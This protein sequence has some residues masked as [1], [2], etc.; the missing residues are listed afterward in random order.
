M[1]GEEF[2]RPR[3]HEV[4]AEF[5]EVVLAEP[6]LIE[7]EDAHHMDDASSEL[8]RYLADHLEG[9]PWLFCVTRRAEGRGFTGSASPTTAVVEP[10]PLAPDDALALAE[11]AAEHDPLPP[12][13]LKTVAERSGGNPQ[14]L[15]DLM[16][17]AT[18]T[19]GAQGL[20]DSVEAAAMATIDRLVPEDRTL[21]RRASVLGQAFHPRMLAWVF[22]EGVPI[23]DEGTWERLD[24][25][26]EYD[27]EGYVRFRRALLRDAAYEGLPYR[28]RR[29]L[30]GAVADQLEAASAGADDEVEALSLHCFLAGR[31]ERAWRYSRAAGDVAR[32]KFAPS[33]AARFYRRAIDAAARAEPGT[34]TAHDVAEVTESSAE[35]LLRAGE[36]DVASG[37][38]ARARRMF[39]DDAVSTARILLREAYIAE[40]GGRPDLVVRRSRRAA[41]AIEG[42]EEPGAPELR[43]D[44][45]VSL[46]WAR[47]IQGRSLEVVKTVEGSLG[48]VERSSNRRALA[49]LY[50]VLDWALFDLGRAD[51]AVHGSSALEIYEEM[52]DI[53][54]LASAHNVLG[55][56]RTS[57]ADGAR[58]SP[59]TSAWWSSSNSS[60]IRSTPRT[61]PSTSPRCCRIRAGSTR[62]RSAFDGS[63]A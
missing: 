27:G 12:H 13:V 54:S 35:M 3:L 15:R 45:A 40:R 46:A 4:V 2:R 14:F 28:L 25:F 21:V 62:R 30:H 33:E 18:A 10:G 61:A 58:R 26:F 42:T 7:I 1:L 38:F 34:I 50:L 9:N 23:P 55:G 6:A 57:R 51:E 17:A 52:G 63:C 44:A 39:T 36:L 19:G 60:A 11:A 53:S 47:H 49:D 29:S 48:E 22:D 43:A 20:P 16:R 8:L 37:D 41:R 5:L 59:A 32:E 31:Y 24:A 56:S